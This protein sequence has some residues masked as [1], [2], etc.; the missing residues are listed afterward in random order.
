M[1]NPTVI[2]LCLQ[3]CKSL[4]T[5]PTR[6]LLSRGMGLSTSSCMSSSAI[7]SAVFAPVIKKKKQRESF[8]FTSATPQSDDCKQSICKIQRKKDR[9]ASSNMSALKIDTTQFEDIHKMVGS[10]YSSEMA[11][12]CHLKKLCLS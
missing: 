7:T 6:S 2:G 4:L 10:I 12:Q 3:S 5:S 8:P 11:F 9:S 1:T